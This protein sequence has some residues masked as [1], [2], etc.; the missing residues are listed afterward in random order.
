MEIRKGLEQIFKRLYIGQ[1]EEQSW[2]LKFGAFCT[3][4]S[5]DAFDECLPA[6]LTLIQHSLMEICCEYEALT[7]SSSLANKTS[8]LSSSGPEAEFFSVLDNKLLADN[9]SQ[10]PKV[11]I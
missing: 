1:N 6:I 4:F 11:S 8:P 10:L 7:F 5:A 9:L 2:N 3:V